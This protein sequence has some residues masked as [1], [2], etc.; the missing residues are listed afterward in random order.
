M[1]RD[2][3]ARTRRGV[4]ATFGTLGAV[5][6]A[7]CGLLF[8]DEIEQSASPAAIDEATLGTTGFQHEG[9]EELTFTETVEVGGESR[10]LRLTNWIA[11]YRKAA[12]EASEG[13]AS[14]HLFSTPS[15][16]VADREANPFARFSKRQLLEEVASRAGQGTIR[17]IREVGSRSASV[18][19][20]TVSFTEYEAIAQL[21][22]QD[23]PI[24]LP[25]VRTTH[26]GDILGI[27]GLYPKQL[28]DPG[29]VYEAAEGTV[30][31]AEE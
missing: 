23:V 29:G 15:V 24:V 10:D 14:V 26:D 19:G 7:G 28:P 17:D 13:V 8:G 22:G 31:P 12:A 6:L 11:N 30:H 27:L 4:L 20:D 9:T 18:L 3:Q 16:R 2:G 25:I 21:E 5:A 1:H